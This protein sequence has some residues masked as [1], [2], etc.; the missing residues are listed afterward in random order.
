M[1]ANLI[2]A[3]ARVGELARARAELAELGAIPSEPSSRSAAASID[4]AEAVL[5]L[6]EGQLDSAADLLQRVAATQ[7]ELGMR[8]EVART[9]MAAAEVERRRRRRGAARSLLE[10]ARQ[11]CLDS[12]SP[13]RLERVD[14]EIA[15]LEPTHQ[16][17]ERL[18][19]TEERIV[20]MVAQGATNREIA[21]ALAIGVTTV[22]AALSHVY[23]KLGVRNRVELALQKPTPAP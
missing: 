15:R 5:L 19:P 6:A 12:H 8:L 9:L 11:I 23:Q 3:L 7:R 2:E 16:P 14:A 1:F 18:T 10:E 20:A 21:K 22:E 13:G 4:R 17:G